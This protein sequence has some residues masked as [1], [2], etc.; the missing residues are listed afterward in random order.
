MANLGG[1][2][3]FQCGVTGGKGGIG[4]KPVTEMQVV[5][6]PCRPA[7]ADV[8]VHCP[9]FAGRRAEESVVGC[10]LPEHEAE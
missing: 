2:T 4:S 10:T 9:R 8:H 6:F 5:T 7:P 1:E 3:A